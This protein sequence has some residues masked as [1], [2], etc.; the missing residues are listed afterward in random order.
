[1]YESGCY[2]ATMLP[3]AQA[4]PVTPRNPTWILWIGAF[5]AVVGGALAYGLTFKLRL[6]AMRR[7][8]IRRTMEVELEPGDY[9]VYHE[10]RSLV[11][12]ASVIGAPESGEE[13]MLLDP[14]GNRVTLFGSGAGGYDFGDYA[15]D[16]RHSFKLREGGTFT[17]RRRPHAGMY[18]SNA[19]TAYAFDSAPLSPQTSAILAGGAAFALL[20]LDCTVVFRVVRRR[21]NLRMAADIV[22]A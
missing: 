5:I 19:S 11:D 12:R 1:M 2:S 14:S 22:R 6:E 20:L 9:T 13:L 7:V 15:G 17:A 21:V 3:G 18:F 10:T 8:D 4:Q 16:A